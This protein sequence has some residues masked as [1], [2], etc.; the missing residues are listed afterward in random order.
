MRPFILTLAAA[1]TLALATGC[2]PD[3][4][5]LEGVLPSGETLSCGEDVILVCYDRGPKERCWYDAGTGEYE[6]NCDEAPD[7]Q[8]HQD[9]GRILF[10]DCAAN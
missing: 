1:I 4:E 8:S 10:Q 3:V 5:C 9:A 6:F 7:G 2:D